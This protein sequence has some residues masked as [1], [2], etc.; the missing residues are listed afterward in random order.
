MTGISKVLVNVRKAMERLALDGLS[1]LHIGGKP[2]PAGRPKVSRWGVYYPKSYEN[3]KKDAWEYVD[4]LEGVPTDKQVA[5]MIEVV[6][7]PM[8][9]SKYTTPMGDADNLCKGPMD[10]M[11]DSE[12]VWLDDRQVVLLIVSKRFTT[13]E[14]DPIGFHVW[15]CEVEE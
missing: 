5:L 10:L 15:W 2:V 13:G 7:P 6:A 9:S 14:E 4:T 3:W 11:T 8:K 12:R 1:Y